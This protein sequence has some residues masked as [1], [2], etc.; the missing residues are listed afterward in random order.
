VLSTVVASTIVW[1]AVTFL[2]PPE[3][4]SVL[5]AFYRRVRPSAG[6]WGPIAREAS[7]VPPRHDVVAN[8]VDWAAGCVLVYA[9][10]F[11]IGK[12]LFGHT[13]LGLALLA[14][15]VVAGSFLYWDLNRRGWKTVID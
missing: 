6:L 3:D 14:L 10:L 8:L 15:A 9:T 11:G 5:L 4:R 12:I 13:P 7:D 2:T 1:L